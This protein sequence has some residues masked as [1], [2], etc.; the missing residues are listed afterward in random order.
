MVRSFFRALPVVLVLVVGLAPACGDSGGGPTPPGQVYE[1]WA[2]TMCSILTSCPV[3]HD[4]TIIL[5]LLAKANPSACGSFLTNLFDQQAPTNNIEL[6]V[7]DGRVIYYADKLSECLSTARSACNLDL[8]SVPACHQV[9]EGTVAVGG[10]CRINEECVGDAF[11][12][13][14]D[15]GCPG[16]CV[17]RAARGAGCSWDGDCSQV[18][19]P[20]ACSNVDICVPEA[21]AAPASLGATCGT[22]ATDTASTVTPCAAGLYCDYDFD[23]DKSI[24]KQYA[25]E[26]AACGDGERCASG[27][28]CTPSASGRSC[29]KVAIVNAVGAVCNETDP[30]KAYAGCNVFAR[31]RCVEG[32]CQPLGDGSVGSGCAPN[33]D[34]EG[35]CDYGNFCDSDTATCMAEKADGSP[36]QSS[37]ECASHICGGSSDAETC[38]AVTCQ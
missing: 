31:L 8:E 20:S 37:S 15:S 34:L 27:L 14:S 29:T 18:E 36:C 1:A 32:Q 13:Q 38:L 33:F 22:A 25:A 11:C 5:A 24:C 12:D 23:L 17:A 9:F 35:I 21:T 4:D 2:S 7:S 6:A 28:A 10:T 30:T 16:T 19:G 26:G 3:T